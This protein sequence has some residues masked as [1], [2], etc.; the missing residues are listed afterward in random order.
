M[1]YIRSIRHTITR[2]KASLI[3]SFLWFLA[4]LVAW[5]TTTG[6]FGLLSQLSVQQLSSM[7]IIEG[8]LLLILIFSLLYL[9]D[10][11][12]AVSDYFKRHE[13]Q[14]NQVEADARYVGYFN[15]ACEKDKD[16]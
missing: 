7:V 3:A 5:P 10:Q 9:L 4:G 1:K 15:E 6:L 2:D 14:W 12:S 13:I 8:L 11:R 16:K